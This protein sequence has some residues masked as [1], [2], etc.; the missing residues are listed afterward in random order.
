[1]N[2]ID[3]FIIVF[4]GEKYL[5]ACIR[6]IYPHA[7]KIIVAEGAIKLMANFKKYFRSSDRTIDIIKKFDKIKLIQIPRHWENKTEMKNTVLNHIESEIL[8]QI[9]Y[10]EFYF[11]DDI[12]KIRKVF[13]SK[14][15]MVHFKAYHFWKD[16]THYK[17]GGKWDLDNLR[18]YRNK[19]NLEFINHN[20]LSRSGLL[21]IQKNFKSRNLGRIRFHYGHIENELHMIDKIKFMC[22]RDPGREEQYRKDLNDWRKNSTENLMKYKGKHPEEI[23]KL[24]DKGELK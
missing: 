4:E 22:R 10:D 18:V 3:F 17:T 12:E 21:Y 15:D 11:H 9:D 13:D 23:Q 24:I 16:F 14:I 6:Q 5:E 2:D 20:I 1:M 8:W 7:H 19:R